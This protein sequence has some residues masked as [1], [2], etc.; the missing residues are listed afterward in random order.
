MDKYYEACKIAGGGLLINK[1]PIEQT[2]KLELI[3]T[4]HYLHQQVKQERATGIELLKDFARAA[5]K[6]SN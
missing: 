6:S 2:S 5:T 3:Q 4:V 1:K